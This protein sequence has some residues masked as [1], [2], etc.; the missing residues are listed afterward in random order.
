M[1]SAW[2]T[3]LLERRQHELDVV[4]GDSVVVDLAPFKLATLLFAT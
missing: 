3:D 2:R 4:A 1:T